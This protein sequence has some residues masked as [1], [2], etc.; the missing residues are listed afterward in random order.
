[1]GEHNVDPARDGDPWVRTLFIKRR[2]R[3]DPPKAEGSK[4]Q[5]TPRKADHDTELWI[6]QLFHRRASAKSFG[7]KLLIFK[8]GAVVDEIAL[9]ERVP[10]TVIG[11]HPDADVQL[12]A[13]KLDMFHARVLHNDGRFY[14]EDLASEAGTLIQRKRLKPKQPVLLHDGCVADI[15]GFRLQF[16]LPGSPLEDEET[17]LDLEELDEIPHFFYT[18]RVPPPPACPLLSHLVDA[19][20]RIAMWRE[21]TTTLTVADLIEETHDVKTFRLVGEEPLLFSYRPGQFVTFVLDID[22]E[23]VQRSY[24]MSS[25]PSRPH[26]LE[27]TVKRVPGGRVSNWLCDRVKLGDMLRIKGPAGR[28]TCFEYPAHKLLLIG[29]GS[30]ITP[31]MSMARWI[32]DT[33]SRVDVKM[34]ASFRSPSEIIF[35][36]ELELISARHSGFHVA[37]TVTSAW[38]GTESWTG[39]TGRISP[40]MI[41]ML[42]PDFRERHIFMCGPEEFMEGVKGILRDMDFDLANLHTE[43]FGS[44]RVVAG[45]KPL[46]S[47]L[48]LSGTLHKVTFSKSGIIVDTDEH[49]SL[50]DLAEAHGVEIEYSCRSGSCGACEVKCKGSVLMSDECSIGKR[51]KDAGFVYACCCVAKSDLELLA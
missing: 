40:H 38:R 51:E 27:V 26:V 4:P 18:P 3:F 47:D 22:G 9:D 35:R 31:V 10:E 43:S 41:Q 19:R 25:T 12:E 50:L 15:P 32:T 46:A 13:F 34:L 29:A 49:V 39:F 16:V 7:R 44:G 5:R 28:F 45:A 36:K 42:S 8:E 17:E 21:G 14:L 23:T 11:R 33:A 24:S 6:K 2:L 30:G 1:M 20:D 48:K 37:V